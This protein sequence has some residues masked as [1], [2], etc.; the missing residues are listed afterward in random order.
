MKWIPGFGQILTT[1]PEADLEKFLHV[2]QMIIKRCQDSGLLYAA[3]GSSN[4]LL[5]SVKHACRI[6]PAN[7]LKMIEAPGAPVILPAREHSGPAVQTRR[8]WRNRVKSH[9][10]IS[11]LS[12][13]MKTAGA[14]W[15][16][17]LSL[18]FVHSANRYRYTVWMWSTVEVK[19]APLGSSDGSSDTFTHQRF[20]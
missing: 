9:I 2:L 5:V 19:S 10:C 11:D 8:F 13:S 12:Y 7:L 20:R 4:Q 16:R 6:S 3:V 18:T 14:C 1:K 15:N 17:S